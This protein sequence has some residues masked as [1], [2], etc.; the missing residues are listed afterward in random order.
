MFVLQALTVQ[1]MER[2]LHHALTDKRGLG[3]STINIEE[4]LIHAIAVFANGDARTALNTLD[5]AA[6]YETV[7]PD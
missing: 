6:G 2:L 4:R 5:M 1:D 3:N 7:S